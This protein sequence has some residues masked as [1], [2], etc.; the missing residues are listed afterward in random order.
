[1]PE[2]TLAIRRSSFR[3]L[4]SGHAVSIGDV[5]NDARLPLDAAR[6]AA[7]LMVSVGMA[8]LDAESVI[9]MDGLTTHQTRHRMV[10]NGVVLWT[11]CAYDIVGI[12]AALKA[13]AVGTTQC[14]MCGRAIDVVVRGGIPDPTTA[15]GW[16]PNE[17]C[18]NVMAEF[19]PS[20]LLFCSRSHLEEWRTEA[21]GA[22][23][24][25]LNV[26]SLAER[27]RA[28]WRELVS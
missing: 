28:A 27:G 10:L 14:G 18:S 17:S 15:I 11:W 19:C 1:M 25:A 3:L 6:E 21:G 26:D 16:L 8:E 2:A 23:G 22:S 7:D 13:D 4:Q 20:A 9:G 12:A 5:A 24:E